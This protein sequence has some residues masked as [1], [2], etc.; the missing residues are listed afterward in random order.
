MYLGLVMV[1][2]LCSSSVNV[3]YI[4]KINVTR[5]VDGDTIDATID[6]G[7]DITINKRIRLHGIDAP[8]TRTRDKKEKIKG[9]AAKKR[10]EQIV[11]QQ[12]GVLYL[13]SMDRGKYGRCVGVLFEV[14]FDDESVND[15]L[16][17]EGHATAYNK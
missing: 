9:L 8:E 4:Y 16:V 3:D 13:K 2:L 5:V 11:E 17:S 10:L 7:F 12:D 1:N 6:L 15:L 14:N